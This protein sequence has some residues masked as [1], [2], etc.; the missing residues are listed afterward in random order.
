MAPISNSFQTNQTNF[1][2]DISIKAT[3]P[4]PN[5]EKI[6][7]SAAKLKDNIVLES[8]KMATG[9]ISGAVAST[10]TVLTAL[11]VNKNILMASPSRCLIASASLGILPGVAGALST[12]V[13][14][15]KLINAAV[16][17]GAGA[18]TGA[19]QGAILFKGSPSSIVATA[20][21]GAVTGLA[22][23]LITE[24]INKK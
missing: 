15:N 5:K 24:Y 11:S 14:D 9:A 2:I 12:N 18:V 20:G 7:E 6:I 19:I 1:G 22:G 21:L 8:P 10:V 16:G 4:K 17:F 3:I 13:S 23:N